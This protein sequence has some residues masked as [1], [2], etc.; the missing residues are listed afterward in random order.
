MVCLRGSGRFWH[1]WKF[2][3]KW[4]LHDCCPEPFNYTLNKFYVQNKWET[5]SNM[6]IKVSSLIPIYFAILLAPF[7]M[8]FWNLVHLHRIEIKMNHDITKNA[9][10]AGLGQNFTP[11]HWNKFAFLHKLPRR[12]AGILIIS[13]YVCLADCSV[14]LNLL[15]FRQNKGGEIYGQIR[16]HLPAPSSLSQNC[17]ACTVDNTH[18]A[19][20]F[21]FIITRK[22]SL[23]IRL[24]YTGYCP[25]RISKKR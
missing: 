3:S 19:Y 7:Q 6:Q 11:D 24:A 5:L 18:S 16:G 4:H 13:V 21:N 15:V 17:C 10:D 1:T 8:K 12:P 14:C 22:C 9:N 2:H 20:C 25:Q 23:L